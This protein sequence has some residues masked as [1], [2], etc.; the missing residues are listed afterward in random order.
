MLTLSYSAFKFSSS[1]ALSSSYFWRS[2]LRSSFSFLASS[3]SFLKLS[4]S[5]LCSWL[6][7]FYSCSFSRDI[8]GLMSICESLSLSFFWLKS[9][10]PRST[11][12]LSRLCSS[13]I[14]FSL[15]TRRSL[16]SWN[17][18]RDVFSCFWTSLCL[19]RFSFAYL[20]ILTVNSFRFSF[21]WS[22]TFFWS[23]YFLA[24]VSYF[25]FAVIRV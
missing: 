10:W 8:R 13:S 15:E 16:D 6:C 18:S 9:R 1:F 7:L 24:R 14:F 3:S 11:L 17:D 4:T 21:S 23:S 19:S 5:D 20:A 22:M 25:S 12:W 2:M